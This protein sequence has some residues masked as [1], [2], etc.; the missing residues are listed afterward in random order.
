[1]MFAVEI[2]FATREVTIG[3]PNGL[4]W[5]SLSTAI[6]FGLGFS[7]MITLGLVPAMLAAPYRIRE[8]GGFFATMRNIGRAIGRLFGM[9]YRDS[10]SPARPQPQPAE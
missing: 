10:G 2:N 9:R 7:K 5:V 8:Q 1:M 4:M 6:V 3:G